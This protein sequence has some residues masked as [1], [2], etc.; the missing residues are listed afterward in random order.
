MSEGIFGIGER[1]V[2]VGIGELAVS[3]HRDTV[4]VTHALGS[5]IA[6][7]LY[8]PTRRVAGMLHYLLPLSSA[9]RERAAAQP[10]CY[11]DT[12]IPL[13]FREMYALGC[14]KRDLIVKAAGGAH[15]LSVGASLDVGRRNY[16]VLRKL[17]WRNGVLIAAQDVGG[18]RP[19]TARLRVADGGIVI[20]SG[21]E[22]REL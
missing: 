20:S 1:Q 19:R 13:L 16:A 10:A 22:E 9:N 4:L 6:L 8:D 18:E 5:C 17:L 3:D 21:R 15:C 7:M 11:G 2:V 12:G 14:N